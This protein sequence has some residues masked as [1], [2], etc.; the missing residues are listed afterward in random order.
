MG[1]RVGNKKLMHTEYALVPRDEDLWLNFTIKSWDIKLNIIFISDS[2]ENALGQ[3]SIEGVDDYGVIK[4][5]GWN[6]PSGMVSPTFYELGQ[7]NGEVVHML[8]NCQGIGSVTR[9]EAQF[10]MEDNTHE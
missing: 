9:F 10:F 7:T 6:S 1:V 4:L 3:W 5:Y 2:P 8:L